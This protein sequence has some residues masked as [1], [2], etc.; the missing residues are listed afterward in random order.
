MAAVGETHEVNRYEIFLKVA[1]LGN[2][3]RAAEALSYTQSGVSHAIRALER[4]CHVSL[5][6][7]GKAGVTLTQSAR[8]LLPHIQ[9]LVNQRRDL[10]QAIQ[11]INHVVAGTLRVGTFTSVSM[12]WLPGIIRRFREQNPQAEFDIYDGGYGDIVERLRQGRVDCGFLTSVAV[13]PGLAFTPLRR[14]EMLAILP[15]QSELAQLDAVPVELLAQQ[16]LV[17]PL[18][19][20]DRDIRAALGGA[21]GQLRVRYALNEDFSAMAMVEQGFGVSVMPDL[22]LRNSSFRLVARPLEPRQYRTIGLAT[23]D[24]EGLSALTRAFAGFLLDPRN[25]DLLE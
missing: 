8:L 25:A 22:M 2:I 1:E 18:R 5:L 20:S 16:E 17:M 24:S 21:S 15:R 3:T 6:V 14:D 23:R 7:R 10:V 4:E 19:G 11:E 9:A 13:E 12:Q